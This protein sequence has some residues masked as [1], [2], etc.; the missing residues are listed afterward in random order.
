M[1]KLNP[2]DLLQ[3]K[4]NGEHFAHFVDR[5]IRAE[6]ALGGLL[7]SDI[8]TPVRAH[9]R[10]GGVDAQITQAIPRDR[11]GWFGVP[12]CWQFKS[13]EAK[14][15][16]DRKYKSKKR[17][18]LQ[19]ALN[20]PYAAE[21]IAEGYGYRFCLLGDIS[22]PKITDWEKQ[23]GEGARRIRSDAASPRVIHGRDLLAWAE[24][25]P[26]VIAWLRNM[27]QEVLHWDAWEK[28]CCEVTPAYVPNPS[29]GAVRE[30]IL[31]HA[32][33]SGSCMGGP[34]L[35]IG[36]AAG[37]GKTRLVLETLR[38]SE[39]SPGL[40]V[41][42][43]DE[44]AARTGAAHVAN[45][46]EQT[47]IIVADECSLDSY[48]KL[49]EMLVGHRDRIRVIGLSNTIGKGSADEWLDRESIK[50]TASDIL[51]RNFSHI[52]DMRRAQ[53]ADFTKGFVRFAADMCQHDLELARGDASGLLKSVE[54]YV[55]GR[56]KGD[57]LP[58]VSLLALFHK[59][60]FQGEVRAEIDALCGIVGR[61]RQDFVERG[62]GRSRVA[63]LRGSGR[64]IL[65]CHTGSRSGCLVQRGLAVLGRVRPGRL[66]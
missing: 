65:V 30:R 66:P 20:E 22:P 60:G 25:F 49:N 34:C 7:Q 39:A 41:Y 63:R 15:I 44:L 54:Q 33:L 5:L 58:L 19:Q 42:A 26:A 64:A 47:A 17:N 13:L 59:V 40:V 4:G 36:G 55:R 2:R 28:N 21:L 12:T 35:L 24:R 53:Y 9:V 43:A 8:R 48:N 57:H 56:L 51:A 18:D 46:S 6:A 23:L 10:D 61:D 45:T 32:D 52:P 29:W 11:S 62:E 27:T 14:S 31:R 16:N 37:V 1:W 3:F 50:G 38:E